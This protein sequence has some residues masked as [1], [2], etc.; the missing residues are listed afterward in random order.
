M[1]LWYPKDSGFEL[2]AFSDVDHASFFD[3]CKSSSG[4]IQFLGDKL[5]S[6]S[7]KKQDCTAMS[8]AEADANIKQHCVRING[9]PIFVRYPYLYGNPDIGTAV[10][11]QKYLLASIGVSA[12]D[13][14]QLQLENLSRR[15]IY[16][17]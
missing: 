15:F 13:K 6:W 1:G 4:R 14:P 16:E 7:S 17:S 8:T 2:I 5:V 9:S 12:L 10:E 11:Y 3:T